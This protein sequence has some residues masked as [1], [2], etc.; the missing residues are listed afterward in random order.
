M[1]HVWLRHPMHMHGSCHAYAAT[2]GKRNTKHCVYTQAFA[3]LHTYMCILYICTF[4]HMHRY[5]FIHVYMCRHT[6]LCTYFLKK[7][8]T[9]ILDVTKW[10]FGAK[11]KGKKKTSLIGGSLRMGDPCNNFFWYSQFFL[12]TGVL[13]GTT[14][15]G[16]SETRT[17]SPSHLIITNSLSHLNI[18]KSTSHLNLTNS[19]NHLVDTNSLSRTY[20]TKSMSHLKITI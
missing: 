16:K 19:L 1:S 9:H 8:C 4:R 3:H 15:N 10:F 7:N 12:P 13:G 2:L 11:K 5:I 20:M 17:N 14:D 18:T 6:Y